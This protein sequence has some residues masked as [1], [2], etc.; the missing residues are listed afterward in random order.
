MAIQILQAIT[1][2]VNYVAM[3]R[4]TMAEGLE[5]SRCC[6]H[7]SCK[8]GKWYDSDG[9]QMIT[10]LASPDASALWTEIGRQHETFHQESMA[11]VNSRASN[12]ELAM[13]LETAM[14]QRS[15]VLVNRLL[16]L[17]S[18]VTKKGVS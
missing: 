3:V 18:L 14:L 5:H 10:A 8:F 12:M 7:H 4:R 9:T 1:Q 16:E 6:D 11:A 13:G 17:D 15:T 2:H